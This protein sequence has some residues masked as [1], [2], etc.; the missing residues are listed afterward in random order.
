MLLDTTTETKFLRLPKVREIVGGVGAS[1]IWSWVK[2][3]KFP[4]P[5]RLS[6]N[7]TAWLA[8][9]VEKWAQER[10]I[11]SKKAVV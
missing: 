4:Q 11:A 5:V 6:E 8:A 7:C 9:D 2:Q 1:T 10:I 3:G